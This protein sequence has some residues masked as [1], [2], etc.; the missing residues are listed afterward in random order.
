[1]TVTAA[2]TTPAPLVL[3]TDPVL[4]DD[5]LRLAAAAGITPEVVPDVVAA[6]RRWL[7]AR[8]VIVDAAAG[9]AC[10]SARLPARSGLVIVGRAERGDEPADAIWQLA[11]DL[12][13]DHVAVLPA[14]E[15]WLV[16]R[17]AAPQPTGRRGRVIAVV[18]GC[19]GAGA[20]VLSAALAITS[21]RLGRRA[22]L[23]D[24][25]PL[26]SGLDLAVGSDHPE[27]TR[28]PDLVASTDMAAAGSVLD[29][30]PRVGELCLLCWDREQVCAIPADAMI[31]AL[32]AA[33]RESDLAVIDL[34]RYPDESSVAALTRADLALV[35]V[36]AQVRAAFAAVRVAAIVGPH[37]RRL[38]C[39]VRVGG[40]AGLRARDIAKA[41]RLPLAGSLRPEP[42]L[43][44]DL[45]HG[46]AP[47]SKV[48]G[49]LARL[50][51]QLV[52][53]VVNEER[54]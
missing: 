15:P 43:G 49:P 4:A 28:W 44:A 12:G 3:V 54:S 38:E 9:M 18:A 45:E 23:I 35:V 17:L 52:R 32:D 5:V 42:G 19:G 33:T 47:G 29:A 46:R 26:G 1:M 37:C 53:R 48:R 34:P 31:T 25:D 21:M 13:A 41:I 16:D 40:P 2:S 7:S 36:P 30:L 39:V 24:A 51:A 6:R 20:S 10:R 14:A 8:V 22:V 50:T 27:G 11:S